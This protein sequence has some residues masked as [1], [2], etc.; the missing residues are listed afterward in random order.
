MALAGIAF[1]TIGDFQLVRFRADPA[2]AGKVME[3]GL[4]RYTRHPNYF[5]DAMTWWGL[6]L[7]A[8]DHGWGLW[9]APGPLLITFLLT[10]W[11]G[12]PTVEGRMRR[13]KPDYAAYAARTSAFIPWPPRRA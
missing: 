6:W 9:T 11:S 5:G 2:N 3:R 4:W 8:A 7:I 12:V 10:R 1:E 13:R